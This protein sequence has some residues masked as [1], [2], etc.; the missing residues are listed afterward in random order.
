VF[1]PALVVAAIALVLPAA[2]HARVI[3][4]KSVLPPGQSGFVSLAGVADGTGSPHLNDQTD[5]FVNF[6]FKPAT[7]NLPGETQEPRPGV[8]IVR[9]SYGVPAIT[10]ATMNDAWWGAGYA[11]AEDRLFQ[12]EVFRR[13]AQGR[14]AEVLGKSYLEMDIETRRDFYTPAELDQQLARLPADVQGYF[15]AYRDGV[16]AYIAETQSDPSKLPGEF[17][18]L[19]IGAPREFTLTDSA[20][21][22]VYLARTIPSGSGAELANLAAFQGIGPRQFSRLLPLR[23]RNPVI[24]VPKRHGRFPSNPGRTRRD[25]RIAWRKSVKFASGLPLPEEGD[26]GSVREAQQLPLLGR[27]GKP[28]GSDVWAIRGP[29]KRASLFTG[30]QL[31]YSIPELLVELEVH[32]PDFHARGVTAAGVPVV[33]I[34]RNEHVAWGLTSGLSDEDDLYAEQ[35]VDEE[36]YRFKGEVRKMDCRDETFSWKPP[37][38]DLTD[39]GGFLEGIIGGGGTPAGEQTERICRTVHGP[40]EARAGNVAYARRYAIW[41]RET[42]TINGLLA[43]DRAKSIRDVDRAMRKVTWNENT[44]AADD[45]GNIGYWHPGLLPRKPKRW[46]ERL[47]YPG[48]GRAEWRGR[49]GVLA[50]KQRPKVINPKQGY[51]FNWN[52]KPSAGWTE[53]DAATRYRVQGRLHH[54]GW[55][56]RQVRRVA[57]KRKGFGLQSTASIDRPAGTVSQQRP[58]FTKQ[59]R[60]ARRGARGKAKQVLDTVLAWDGNYDRTAADGTIDA[61]AAAWQELKAAA[62]ATKLGGLDDSKELL[63]V[64]RSA[65]FDATNGET[66]SLMTLSPLGLRRAATHAHGLLAARFG[67]PDPARWR[68]PRPMTETTSMGAGAFP[69]F[70]LFDRGTWQQVVL[71]GP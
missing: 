71:L 37:P 20:A 11:I 23:Q 49:G 6:Q 27:T 57:R 59:L 13:A 36:S 65:D 33:G 41:G 45:K 50:V 54:A 3:D 67:S 66:Y 29:R 47:P 46:D 21:I 62:I 1:R 8:K 48:D 31:G 32:G 55:L 25:D 9:D 15:A 68:Q 58:L 35:L 4:A 34:G 38:T 43:L 52:N 18:A 12:I 17:T 28:Q 69:E 30:P 14:L 70:P 26:L 16:N 56:G 19:G 5:L 24:T 40:V 51:L 61:G 44:T 10:G 42:E 7:F 63:Q 22:G 60:R 64:E 53:G 39:P 2:A